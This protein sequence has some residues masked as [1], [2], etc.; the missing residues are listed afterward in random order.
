MSSLTNKQIFQGILYLK[1]IH[2]PLNRE[3]YDILFQIKTYHRN[4]LFVKEQKLLDYVLNIQIFILEEAKLNEEHERDMM[5]FED[6]PAKTVEELDGE[7]EKHERVMMGFEDSPAKTVAE[8]DGEIEEHERMLENHENFMMGFQDY[9]AKTVEELNKE[10]RELFELINQKILS[11]LNYFIQQFLDLSSENDIILD[12]FEQKELGYIKN[13]ILV[14]W[15][16]F[17]FLVFIGRFDLSDLS[18]LSNLSNLSDLFLF[19]KIILLQIKIVSYEK[20]RIVYGKT[21]KGKIDMILNK[22]KINKECLKPIM[23]K[24]KIFISNGKLEVQGP[25]GDSLF[26]PDVIP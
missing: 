12:D 17:S 3:L 14:N 11:N 5:G 6:Y 25:N 15:I 20:E 21:P 4:E 19:R 9:P 8:L 16:K 7:I 18:D 24:I 26:Q 10:K 13:N 23:R 1:T 22:E 2:C